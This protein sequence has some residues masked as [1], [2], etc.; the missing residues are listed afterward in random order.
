ML[1][2]AV[3]T[4]QLGSGVKVFSKKDESDDGKQ[5]TLLTVEGSVGARQSP[6]RMYRR[7]Y[8]P[9]RHFGSALVYYLQQRGV[10]VQHRVIEGTVPDGARL[11]F[12]PTVELKPGEKGRITAVGAHGPLKRRLMDMGLLPGQEVKVVK[13]APLGAG[14]L[15]FIFLF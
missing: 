14:L 1:E 8:A 11:V 10:K 15:L 9:L 13:V 4:E 2:G 7:V 5:L 6:F 3:M 12:G